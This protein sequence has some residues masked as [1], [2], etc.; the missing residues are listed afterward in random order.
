MAFDLFSLNI[1]DEDV[2]R[3]KRY[4]DGVVIEGSTLKGKVAIVPNETFMERFPSATCY[5]PEEVRVLLGMDDESAQKAHDV[6]RTF[7]GR[8]KEKT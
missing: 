7:G 2:E 8:L 3:F 1:L 5:L 6:K 4:D